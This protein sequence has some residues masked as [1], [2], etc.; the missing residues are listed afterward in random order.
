MIFQDSLQTTIRNLVSKL[1]I[2]SIWSYRWSLFKISSHI[3]F[4]IFFQVTQRWLILR[5]IN[6]LEY[7]LILR[8]YFMAGVFWKSRPI[9]VFWQ[10]I[11]TADTVTIL[12][13]GQVILVVWKSVSILLDRTPIMQKLIVGVDPRR[14]RLPRFLSVIW[15]IRLEY[16]LHVELSFI[17]KITFVVLFYKTLVLKYLVH[18]KWLFI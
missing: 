6:C 9:T 3:L 1:L 13:L 17:V 10:S 14:V 7:C 8:Q 5:Y 15:I 18:H 4:L 2:L 12:Y 16:L 11:F